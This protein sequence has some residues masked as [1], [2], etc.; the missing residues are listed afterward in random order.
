MRVSRARSWM[1]ASRAARHFAFAKKFG[2]PPIRVRSSILFGAIPPL[3][4][5]IALTDT[6]RL[7]LLEA[8]RRAIRPLPQPFR[9]RHSVMSCETACARQAR[10]RLRR[11]PRTSS[12]SDL[13]GRPGYSLPEIGCI[14]AGARVVT[15]AVTVSPARSDVPSDSWADL[16]RDTTASVVDET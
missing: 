4:T 3:G 15:R 10:R 8:D 11:C 13:R 2:C 6:S 7:H 12:C 14:V 5:M 9:T 16:S 1:L